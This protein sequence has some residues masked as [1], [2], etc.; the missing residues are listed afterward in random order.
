M[1]SLF[2][3]LIGITSSNIVESKPS[4]KSINSD[5]IN[6]SILFTIKNLGLST[7]AKY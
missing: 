5:F 6:L 1:L 2:K 3:P 7:L 4:S